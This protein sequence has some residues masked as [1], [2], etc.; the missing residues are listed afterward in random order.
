M[1]ECPIDRALPTKNQQ[2]GEDTFIHKDG[3]FFPVAFTASPILEGTVPVGTVVEVRDTTDEKA[4]QRERERILEDLRAAVAARDEFLSI[5]SHELRTPLTSLD[6]QLSGI[7]RSLVKEPA[8]QSID[9]LRRRIETAARQADRLKALIDGLLHVSRIEMGRLHL[10]PKEVDVVELV[11]EA[12]ERAESDAARIGSVLTTRLPR[13]A[14]ASVDRMRIDQALTNLLSNAIKYGA[15][16]PIEVALAV[17]GEHLSLT[18]R[19]QGVGIATQDLTRIFGRFERAVA[20]THYGGLG[21]GLYIANQ[22]VIAHGGVIHAAS[23]P[24]QGATFTIR[25]PRR[26]PP[27]VP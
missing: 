27:P 17:D 16:K 12:V 19:D 13:A 8:Q 10:E 5:A 26:Q 14:P 25:L 20:S 7:Q 1:E 3:H 21:L 24:G 11:R 2:R 22:I 23:E 15:G 6:L 4:A 9:T 18:V